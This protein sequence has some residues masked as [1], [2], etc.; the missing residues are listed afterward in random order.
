MHNIVQACGLIIPISP[1]YHFY[2][3]V[4]YTTEHLCEE[5]TI[6]I[7]GNLCF[8]DVAG[9]IENETET[10]SFIQVLLIS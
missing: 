10:Q 7:F 4:L 5:N 6:I 3:T 8:I 1:D 2:N 9:N